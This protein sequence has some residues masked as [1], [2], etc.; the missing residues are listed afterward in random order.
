MSALFGVPVDAAYHLVFALTNLLTPV[1]GGGAAVA[2]IVV[3]TVAARLLV[4]PLTFR[5]LRGQRAQAALAPHVTR[6]RQRYAGQPE[7]LQRELVALYQRAGT[8]PLTGFAPLL[9]QWPVFSV[10]YL[11]FRSPAVAGGPNQLLSRTLLGAPLGSHLLS[12]S[13]AF[14]AHGAVFFGVLI[15]LAAACWLVTRAARRVLPRPAPSAVAPGTARTNAVLTVVGTFLPY[16]TVLIAVFT[17]LA[18]AV[19]LVASTGWSA[20][21]RL[22][23]AARTDRNAAL[24]G[25][26]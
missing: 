9:A 17:P 6:L 19:Y 5:A 23:F 11:L 20:A 13:G 15:L 8:S 7:R 4:A 24:A 16:L 3:F 12:G 1:L 14:S 2:A 10:L 25:N 18:A 22:V 26:G 21:E